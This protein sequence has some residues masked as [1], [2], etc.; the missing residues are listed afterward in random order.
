MILGQTFEIVEVSLS[1]VFQFFTS[2][3]FRN[4]DLQKGRKENV[5]FILAKW[6]T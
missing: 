3:I 5:L 6:S 4:S 1:V 2:N